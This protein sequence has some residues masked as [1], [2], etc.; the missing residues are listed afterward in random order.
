[1]KERMMRYVINGDEGEV[2]EP[3]QVDVQARDE[4]VKASES[5]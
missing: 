3:L 5:K 4:V 2:E 1:M